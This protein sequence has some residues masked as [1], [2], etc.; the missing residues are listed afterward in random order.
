MPTPKWV[1]DSAIV[2]VSLTWAASVVVDMLNPVY[3]PPAMIA[4]VMMAVVGYLFAARPDEPKPEPDEPKE[5]DDE[6]GGKP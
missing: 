3:E 5:V 6:P 1:R 2:G 4:P